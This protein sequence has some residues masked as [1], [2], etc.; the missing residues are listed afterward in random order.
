MSD[1]LKAT[2]KKY[3]EAQQASKALPELRKKAI[4]LIKAEGLTK[5]KFK[6]SESSVIQYQVYTRQSDLSVKLVSDVLADLYPSLDR[7]HVLDEI[8]RRRST[9]RKQVETLSGS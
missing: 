9:D 7:K 3:H 8:R 6:L 1:A 2:L 5:N 4:E